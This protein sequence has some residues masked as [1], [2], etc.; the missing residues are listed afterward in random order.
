[1]KTLACLLALLSLGKLAAAQD[2]IVQTDGSKIIGVVQEVGTAEIKYKKFANQQTSPVYDISKF[3]VNSIHYADG[4]SDTFYPFLQPIVT[5]TTATLNPDSTKPKIVYYLGARLSPLNGYNATPINNYWTNLFK[6]EPGNGN[7]QLASG[8]APLYNYTFGWAYIS[9]KQNE[10]GLEEQ[11][12]TTAG[13]GIHTSAQYP[14]GTSGAMTVNYSAVNTTF[15]YMHGFDTT[16][17]MQLGFEASLDVGF[18]HGTENDLFYDNGPGY[19][20]NTV[21]NDYDDAHV[22]SHLALVGR[23]FVGK[24]QT[25][26][27]ELR[28]GYRFMNMSA[29]GNDN[30]EGNPNSASMDWSGGFVSLGVILEF[31]K[32]VVPSPYGYYG[33]GCYS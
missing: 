4:A 24:S 20:S 9:P 22:G 26:G 10:F 25:L 14:D 23:Y 11:Y 27:F 7:L 6:G 33:C 2:T 29:M 28:A 1:M 19:A 5:P 13:N 16:D 32:T 30:W 3:Q 17:R 12:E 21:T 15:I 8:N 18:L 31:K